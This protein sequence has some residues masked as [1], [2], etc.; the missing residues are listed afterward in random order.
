MRRMSVDAAAALAELVATLTGPGGPFE[1]VEEDVRGRRLP[2][3]RQRNHALPE[4]LD[5]AASHDDKD[6]LVTADRRVTYAQ[7]ENA[8]AALATRLRDEFG[9]GKGDRV[10]I[11]GANSPEWIVAFWAVT[12]LGA[13]VAAFNAWWAPPELAHAIELTM[14]KV[15]VSDAADID[16]NRPV[17]ALDGLCAP[18]SG[19]EDRPAADIG[20]D[21]PAVIVF[22]SGTTGRPKGATHSHRNLLAAVDYH[23][24]MNAITGYARPD[25]PPA[26]GRWLLSMPLFHIAGLHNLA[27]PR[28]A[29]GETVVMTQGA[30]EPRRVLDLVVTE[31]VTN[32]AVVPTMAQRLL[33]LPDL[34]DH[35][36]SAL[37]SFTLATA[38]SSRE[39]QDELRRRIAVAKDN[40][41]DS[42]G[43]TESTTAATVAGGPILAD[44]PG[45]VGRP[46]PTV[47][48]DVRDGE[49]WLRSPLSMLGYWNDAAATAAIFDEDGWMRTGDL[50]EMRNGL[51]YL[52]TRRGDLI[53]RGGENVY[54]VEVEQVLEQH[55]A[56]IECAVFGVDHRDLGQEVAA[57][58]V[59]DKSVT[60][61][62][63]A[64]FARQRLAY[65]KVPTAWRLTAEPLPRT[66]TGKVIRRDFR[67]WH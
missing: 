19:R 27:V 46:I 39:L 45:T 11:H 24:L 32:W 51:L 15:I 6:Y 16:T 47:G 65:Y 20:E 67:S 41:V 58:I 62:E 1:I 61:T 21:D 36:L 29:T 18:P 31:R 30:F 28:L 23:R 53:I 37:R 43:L 57:V 26:S 4:L 34:G 40:L 42:Y 50:G 60:P 9:I 22:T 55:P 44:N 54:P 59:H 7:H 48:I 3:Y 14:P 35:D 56:V 13:I 8:V 64:D 49:I 12:S 17:L 38:P 52:T 63:L 5:A 10:A 33:A 25:V 66:V 2:V